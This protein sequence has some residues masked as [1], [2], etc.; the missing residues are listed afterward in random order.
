M[1]DRARA[2]QPSELPLFFGA[3]ALDGGERQRGDH[4]LASLVPGLS[5]AAR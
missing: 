1:V 3:M 5:V 4:Y 2:R